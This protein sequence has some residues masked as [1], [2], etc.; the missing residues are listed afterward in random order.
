MTLTAPDLPVLRWANYALDRREQDV[1]DLYERLFRHEVPL[2]VVREAE[3]SGTTHDAKVWATV[4]ATGAVAM[5][6]PGAD[7]DLAGLVPLTLA[8]EQAG[9]RL[10]P[11]PLVEAA[12]AARALAAVAPGSAWADRAVAGDPLV[13]VA[14]HPADRLPRQVVPA[15]AVASSVLALH[16]D[17]LVVVSAPA[18]A[19]LEN[20][21]LVPVAEWTLDGSV[22]AVDVVAEGPAALAAFD[23]ARRD[24]KV[25][26]AA[27]L[28]GVAVGALEIAADY[29]KVRTAFG[30]PIGTFQALAHPMADAAIGSETARRLTRR[31]A[32]FT[33]HEPAPSERL[34]AM[35][36]LHASD[37]ANRTTHLA[38]HVLGGIGFT[39]EA[40]PQHYYRRAK[41]LVLAGGDPRQELQFIADLAWGPAGDRTPEEVGRGLL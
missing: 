35:A 31:A 37:V 2:D 19:Q 26:T 12:V 34:A 14:L 38:I 6:I 9:R 10:A 40:A 32:W 4:L 3:A 16:G 21:W 24:W 36:L 15:G 22:G 29:A 30:V 25:L 13:S 18:P 27:M 17:R 8:L 28:I 5:G 33:D 23:R 7:G 1:H 41:G 11:V 39:L 20:P